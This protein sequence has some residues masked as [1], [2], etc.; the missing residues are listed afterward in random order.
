MEAFSS[1]FPADFLNRSEPS[2]TGLSLL[3][4]CSS[5]F[6]CR[7]LFASPL[8]HWWLPHNAWGAW[9]ALY[10]YSLRLRM[11]R[12]F[13]WKKRVALLMAA[14]L[15]QGASVGLLIDRVIKSDPSTPKLQAKASVVALNV[16]RPL[17]LKNASEKDEK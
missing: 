1:F 12:Y 17:K 5:S 4:L 13:I 9:E 3:M 11:K 7:G 10:G 16:T 8:Q 6:G 14:A 15:F 2:R